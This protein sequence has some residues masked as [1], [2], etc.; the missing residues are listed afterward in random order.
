[1]WPE[2]WDV[3]E[4]MFS[5]VMSGG[6]ATWSEDQR[7]VVDRR[8]FLEEA[9][10]TWTYGPIH[11]PDGSVEGVLNVAVET[12]DKVLA[13]RRSRVAAELVAAL[14]GAQD[15]SGVRAAVCRTMGA[16]VADHL[17]VDLVL[18]GGRNA[19]RSTGGP[20]AVA[21]REPGSTEAIG[22]LLVEP[23]PL[24][25]WDASLERHIETCATHVAS[26]LAGLHRLEQE[27]RRASALADLDTARSTFFANMSHELRTPLTL[28]SG[29]AHDALEDVRT[30]LPEVHRERLSLIARNSDRLISLVDRLLDLTR[31]EAGVVQPH[32]S[33]TDV[34]AVTRALADGFRPAIARSGLTLSVSCLDLPSAACLDVEMYER[35]VLNLLSNA[36]KFTPDGSISVRLSP[37]RDGFEV[38]VSDTGVGIAA[39]DVERIFERFQQLAPATGSSRGGGAGIGLSLTRE[40]VE[41]MGGRITARS[42]PGVGSTFSVELPMTMPTPPTDGSHVQSIARRPLESFIDEVTLQTAAADPAADTAAGASS[43]SPGGSPARRATGASAGTATAQGP[44]IGT[45]PRL[46]VVE[47]HPDLRRYLVD[48]LEGDYA[49]TAATDGLQGLALAHALRPDL[50]LADVMMPR[51]DGNALVHGLRAHPATAGVPV[52]LLS[53]RAGADARVS[54]IEG[55][56]DDYVVKPFS[57]SELRARLAAVLR[58]PAQHDQEARERR[59]RAAA[60]ASELEAA[61]DLEQVVVTAVAGFSV[62]FDGAAAVRV[63]AGAADLLFTLDGV[64]DPES[65]PGGIRDQL[66]LAS[67]P[68]QMRAQVGAGEPDPVRAGLLLTPSSAS[69][70][71][72]VWVQFREVRLVSVDEEMVGD[73]LARSFAHTVDRVLALRDREAKERQLQQAIESHRSI[74]HAVG[75]LI[76]RHKVTA[77][78]GFEMLRQASLHRNI[79]LRELARRVVETGE[80][81]MQ[82]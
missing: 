7:L 46:L 40:L 27:R 48:A 16:D 32:P 66:S 43:C 79:K 49:V 82:A 37:R 31:L 69:S 17:S 4:P 23:N 14:A 42:E 1:V 13:D 63:T 60:L 35:I 76:E 51:L 59:A 57:L 53:A 81:P 3:I 15:A 39:E 22:C 75:V 74:G 19:D 70:T 68:T 30:P 5:A 54:G 34:S 44:A 56:A 80:E 10:F 45:K 20:R 67:R 26:A 72:R 58:R 8:G 24:R 64:A 38:S 18:A 12:T 28:V 29:P 50:V 21:V 2:V 52:V 78:Q 73:L 9:F 62:L 61:V 65:L 71:C 25:P 36:V 77:V 11:G 6:P 55:G 47:D 41:L 33:E